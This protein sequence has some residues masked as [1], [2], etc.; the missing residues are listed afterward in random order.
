MLLPLAYYALSF[1]PYSSK[2]L[3]AEYGFAGNMIVK[4]VIALVLNHTPEFMPALQF[5][6]AVLASAPQKQ[7]TVLFFVVDA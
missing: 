2:E 7:R 3:S 1:I 4:L 5:V 6:D